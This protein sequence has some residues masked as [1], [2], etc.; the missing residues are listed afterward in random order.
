[1]APG[2]V[3]IIGSRVAPHPLQGKRTHPHPIPNRPMT[4]P[5]PPSG[6]DNKHNNAT[7]KHIETITLAKGGETCHPK[8]A[9]F[10]KWTFSMILKPK[11]SLL[12]LRYLQTV[13][14]KS[15]LP[16][17]AERGV[18][19]N[20]VPKSTTKQTQRVPHVTASQSARAP[21]SFI[22][23]RERYASALRG[24]APPKPSST[25]CTMGSA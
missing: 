17:H 19:L 20:D 5:A 16:L 22:P 18:S 7:R 6:I 24:L 2:S 12:H 14:F 21:I 25:A 11:M 9:L 3:K 10:S 15:Q 1:M 4:D 8:H 23:A 13:A